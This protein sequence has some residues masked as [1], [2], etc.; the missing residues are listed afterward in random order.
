MTCPALL[1]GLLTAL[2]LPLPSAAAPELPAAVPPPA[3][4]VEPPPAPTV[5]SAPS[6]WPQIGLGSLQLLAGYGVGIGGVAAL[7]EAG[8]Y[9]KKLGLNS[10]FAN[11]AYV[12]LDRKSVV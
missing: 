7:A 5:V 8:V 11:V 3:A 12:T 4:L 10:D 9:P 1:A 2:A 6:R